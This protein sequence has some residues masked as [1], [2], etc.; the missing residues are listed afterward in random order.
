M[1]YLK[2]IFFLLSKSVKSWHSNL[3]IRLCLHFCIQIGKE[4]NWGTI[5][6][7]HQGCHNQGLCFIKSGLKFSNFIKEETLAQE[8]LCEFCEISKNTFSDREQLR[9]LLL[10]SAQYCHIILTKQHIAWRYQIFL[11]Y[12]TRCYQWIQ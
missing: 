5:Y 10:S 2:F 1:F 11:L 3:K 12:S 6:T 8:F 9:W 7:P 4:S